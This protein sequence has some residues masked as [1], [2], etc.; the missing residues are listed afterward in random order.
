MSIG[1][2]F[3]NFKKNSVVISIKKLVGTWDFHTHVRIKP[4]VKYLR[5][6]AVNGSVLEIGCGS[7]IVGFEFHK[8][9]KFKQY[10]GIDRDKRVIQKANEIVKNMKIQNMNFVAEDA[11]EFLQR[12]KKIKIDIDV[13]VLYDFLEH[14]SEPEMFLAELKS[15]L[16]KKNIVFIVSVPTPYYPKVFGRQFHEEVGHIIEGY[17]LS[18][19]E[20]LFSSIEYK[21]TKYQYNT[22]LFGNVG[23]YL[24]Y[25]L[26]KNLKGEFWLYIKYIITLPFRIV[27]FNT[28]KISSSIFAVFTQDDK[29]K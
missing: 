25:N 9:S 24:F 13:V 18:D 3:V 29:V 20:Y 17:R 6:N 26:L 22:G 11:F 4:L 15:K 8:H 7:G 21:C 14:I 10:I 23:A 5:K 2:Y 28:A 12:N 1:N 19:L 27:D 16:D